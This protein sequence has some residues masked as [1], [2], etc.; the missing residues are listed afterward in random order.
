MLILVLDTMLHQCDQSVMLM[1]FLR[2]F[3][4]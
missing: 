1:T 4:W 3:R 2:E